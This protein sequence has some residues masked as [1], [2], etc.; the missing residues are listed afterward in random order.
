MIKIIKNGN[1]IMI[2]KFRFDVEKLEIRGKMRV[3]STS[4]IKKIM[5]IRKNRNEKGIRVFFSGS[6]PHSNGESLS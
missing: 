4:K 1:E 6:N 2:H 3:I 5:V